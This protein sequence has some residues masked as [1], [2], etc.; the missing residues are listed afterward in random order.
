MSRLVTIPLLLVCTC[1]AQGNIEIIAV[2]NSA[3]FQPGLPQRG[4][5]ASIFCTG[6]QG[7]LGI[8]S[9]T[10]HPLPYD[11]AGVSVWVNSVPA[12]ILAVAFESGYQQINIQVPWE[13]Q[14]DPFSVD[15]FQN[16]LQAHT[17][18]ASAGPEWSVF[19]RDATGHAIVQHAADYSVVTSRNPA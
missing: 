9:A 11:L 10:T 12:P 4:S 7:T 5:L 16:G 19:F 14:R 8:V 2:T 6:L 15:V 3:D 13:L 1:F 17:E 18:N